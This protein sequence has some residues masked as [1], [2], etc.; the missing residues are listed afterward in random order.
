MTNF[1]F[2]AAATPCPQT[3][4]NSPMISVSFFDFSLLLWEILPYRTVSPSS[5]SVSIWRLNFFLDV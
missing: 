4:V 5:L 3:Q 2:S 1:P